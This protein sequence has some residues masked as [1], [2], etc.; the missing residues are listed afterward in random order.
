MLIMGSSLAV[1]SRR[2][3]ALSRSVSGGHERFRFHRMQ[4]IVVHA[5]AKIHVKNTNVNGVTAGAAARCRQ[6]LPSAIG[7]HA[8]P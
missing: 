2:G 6:G 8:G 5:R 3:P 4:R 7:D 1:R